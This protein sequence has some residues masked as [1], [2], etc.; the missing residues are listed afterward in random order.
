MEKLH[1]KNKNVRSE[2][3]PFIKHFRWMAFVVAISRTV[4]KQ[5]IILMRAHMCYTQRIYIQTE[6][7]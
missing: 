2:E 4:R 1:G 6:M 5:N 3:S 7:M